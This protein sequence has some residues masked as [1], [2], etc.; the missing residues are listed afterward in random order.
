MSSDE[1]QELEQILSTEGQLVRGGYPR[2]GYAEGYPANYAYGYRDEDEYAYLH[3]LWQA[4]RK[5]KLVILVIAVL[6]TSVVTVDIYRSKSIYQAATT[7]EVGSESRMLVRS[8]DVVIQTDDSE[9][10]YAVSLG[11]KT[12]M[13]LLQSR[14]LLEDVVVNLKLDRDPR[15]F[16]VTTKKS[17]WEAVES[18]ASRFRSPGSS[19]AAPHAVKTAVAQ[20][21]DTPRSREESAR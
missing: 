4:I 16:D 20:T 3:R 9:D 18:I 13:R 10:N 2:A 6:I 21:P 15:F 5:R 17:I 7:I 14:P 1:R 8:G 11:M 19:P 12:K